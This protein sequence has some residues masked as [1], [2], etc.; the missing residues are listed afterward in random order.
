M[1]KDYMRDILKQTIE[2]CQLHLERMQQAAQHIRCLYPFCEEKFPLKK[3]EDLTSLDMFT[4][5]LS[6]LQ[7]TMR[8]DLFPEFLKFLGEDVFVLSMIDRLNKL[9]KYGVLKSVTQWKNL[10]DLK[11]NLSHEYPNSYESLVKTLNQVFEKCHILE[12]TLKK[13]INEYSF[14]T[15]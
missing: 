8:E 1:V 11:N 12:Q 13:I 14:R 4:S 6:K 10:R 3:Y 7:D 9:E 5:R 2:E 15:K